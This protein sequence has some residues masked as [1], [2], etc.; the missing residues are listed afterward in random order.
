MRRF[1]AR[2]TRMGMPPRAARPIQF[3][4]IGRKKARSVSTASSLWV[5]RVVTLVDHAKRANRLE[6]A[7]N[8]A[9]PEPSAFLRHAC[10]RTAS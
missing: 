3:I 7:R 1:A 9:M 4:K 5:G 10:Q 8:G 2:L 6:N